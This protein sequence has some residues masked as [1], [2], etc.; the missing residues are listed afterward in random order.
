MR[1]LQEQVKK[2]F[3]YQNLFCPFTVGINCSSELNNFQIFGLQTRIS[4]VFFDNQ[5]FFFAIGQNNFGNKM[6]ICMANIV[7]NKCVCFSILQCRPHWILFFG[8]NV[9]QIK[10]LDFF[11]NLESFTMNLGT[12]QRVQSEVALSGTVFQKQLKRDN[13]MFSRC[14]TV[15]SD[16]VEKNLKGSVDSIPLLSTSVQNSNYRWE[17]LLEVQRQNFAGCFQQM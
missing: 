2:A 4:K 13:G 14:G 9:C 5:N 6:P 11:D 8:A 3:C 17:S 16:K 15:V 12:N 7:C 10:I 1:N